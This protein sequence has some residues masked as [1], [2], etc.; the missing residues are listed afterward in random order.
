V[1]SVEILNVNGNGKV[2]I[3]DTGTGIPSEHLDKIFDRF[4]KLGDDQS[5][6]EYSG[7]GLGLS[8]AKGLIEA[9][10]GK[11]TINSTPGKG[12]LV[13]LIFPLAP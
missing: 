9:Q 10:K 13:T 4:Y 2:K 11:I 7:S 1:V 6:S 8:I 12:T 3:A 5:A